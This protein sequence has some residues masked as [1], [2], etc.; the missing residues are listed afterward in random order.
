MIKLVEKERLEGIWAGDME[1]G[2][3][4]VIVGCAIDHYVDRV[5]QR[6]NNKLIAIGVSINGVWSPISNLPNT[7][8]VR[9]L[10]KGETLIV[11]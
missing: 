1:D 10:E 9:L 6:H 3:V 7:F 2:D 5:V 11:V 8:R 4:G